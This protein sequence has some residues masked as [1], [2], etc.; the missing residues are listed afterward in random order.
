MVTWHSLIAN[1]PPLGW[2]AALT[3]IGFLGGTYIKERLE[4][5]REKTRYQN[6]IRLQEE[7][8]RLDL[9][10]RR[11]AVFSSTLDFY[12]ALISWKK[13][14]L[15]EH[16]ELRRKFFLSTHAAKFLFGGEH[17]VADTMKELHKKSLVVTSFKEHPDAHRGNPEFMMKSLIEVNKILLGDFDDALARLEKAIRPYLVFR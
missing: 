10:D 2:T 14:P 13:E 1:S 17:Q 15:P 11:L 5:A 16:L 4:R 8:I 9:F 3:G 12:D 7:K 6:Q